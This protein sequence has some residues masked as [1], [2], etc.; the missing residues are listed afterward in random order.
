MRAKVRY[1]AEIASRIAQVEQEAESGRLISTYGPSSLPCYSLALFAPH[2]GRL[3]YCSG[4]FTDNRPV[5]SVVRVTVSL[6]RVRGCRH[7]A[8]AWYS[9]WRGG[10]CAHK[11]YRLAGRP[12]KL[13]QV[14]TNAAGKA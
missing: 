12:G 5:S 1:G 13:K 6:A 4:H 7:R 14:T 2:G 3:T 9:A 10:W 8:T 11:L